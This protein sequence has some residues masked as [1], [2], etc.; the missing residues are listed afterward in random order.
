MSW[1]FFDSLFSIAGSASPVHGSANYETGGPN[2]PKRNV[3]LTDHFD[4]FVEKEVDS[5][6][7]KSASEVLRAGLRLLEREQRQDDEKL[8]ALQ[9]LAAVGF[10]A[11]DRGEGT[12]IEG[13]DELGEFLARIGKRA[14]RRVERRSSAK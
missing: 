2:V 6:R 5:G 13:E 11:L 10:D 8:V 1:G 3:D 4:R 14:A 9:K 7:Y 12:E